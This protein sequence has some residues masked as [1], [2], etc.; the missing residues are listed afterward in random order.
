VVP[1]YRVWPEADVDA[2]L[3]DVSRALQWTLENCSKFGGD[4]TRLYMC[5]HSSGAH[6]G[7]LLSINMALKCTS[8]GSVPVRGF[9]GIAGV[10]DI[11]K[12][13]LFEAERGVHMVSPMLAA[14]TTPRQRR[15]STA[16]SSSSSS[17][18]RR[19]TWYDPIVCQYSPVALIPSLSAEE[20]ARLP[21]VM[22]W[23]GLEDPTVPH[24]SSVELFRALQGSAMIA[25]KD[26]KNSSDAPTTIR[27]DASIHL[28]KRVDHLQVVTDLFL[29]RGALDDE[30]VELLND[31]IDECEYQESEE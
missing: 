10:Y 2:Q 4:P 7:A 26:G 31:F 22:L 27:S 24:S 15:L 6:L 12:H 19:A 17:S 21:R 28:F 25:H 1:N 20:R 18:S 9:I 3:E 30:Q 14:H 16:P 23:H 11:G 13:V 8:P 5:G 29:H